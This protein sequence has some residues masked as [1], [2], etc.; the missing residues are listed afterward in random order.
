[1]AFCLQPTHVGSRPVGDPRDTGV[2]S[3]VRGIVESDD[4]LGEGDKAA[5]AAGKRKAHAEGNV[6]NVVR[7]RRIR[8]VP[9]RRL[10]PLELDPERRGPEAVA[11][12]SC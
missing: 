11:K 3:D 9:Q 5:D 8:R 12:R 10:L 1:M 7:E 2:E 6:V 4:V